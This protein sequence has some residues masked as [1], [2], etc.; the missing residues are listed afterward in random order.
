MT[1]HVP[2]YETTK[3]FTGRVEVPVEC[4][5]NVSRPS[6][7]TIESVRRIERDFPLIEEEPE[8]VLQPIVYDDKIVEV[9]TTITVIKPVYKKEVRELI[10]EVPKIIE[11]TVD[12]LVEIPDVQYVYR[13]AQVSKI[14]DRLK[15]VFAMLTLLLFVA[16]LL[17]LGTTIV[18]RER[19]SSLFCRNILCRGKSCYNLIK[20]V[21]SS[22]DCNLHH[23]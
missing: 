16:Y 3:T 7:K 4:H 5:V 11:K 20:I 10:R 12:R 8:E 1:Q 15:A 17:V 22:V 14:S 6:T 21:F 19:N 13:F 9:P 18:S 2:V 23:V